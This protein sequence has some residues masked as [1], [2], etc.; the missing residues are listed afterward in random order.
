MRDGPP[1]DSRTIVPVIINAA[2]GGGHSADDF[3]KL[4]KLFADNGMAARIVPARGAEIGNAAR[5]AMRTHPRVLVAA[6]GDGTVRAVADAVRGT[7]TALGVLPAGTLNHF[8]KDLGI[9]TELEEAVEVLA[10]GRRVAIDIGEV[11]GNTFLNNSSLGL[12]PDM[13]RDRTRQQRRF[14]RSKWAAM[15]WALLATVRRSPLL[16][17]RLC[18][19][20]GHHDYRAPFVFIGNNEYTMEGFDIGTRARLD[21]SRL[22]IYTTH[23][24]T[25]A[26]LAGLALR[27]LFGRLHQAEDFAALT[28][29]SLRV[30]STRRRLLVATDGEVTAMDTPLEFRILP[31]ALTVVVPQPEEK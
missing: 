13:V 3:A 19:D 15:F 6:G 7:D 27:A 2:S 1:Q 25:A 22:S 16:R 26:G 29:Q 24:C 23:R 5:A 18:V 14:R 4:E 28:G 10:N 8:A 17:L 30:E 11:N 21:C 12:Y 20:G 31:R 9:P